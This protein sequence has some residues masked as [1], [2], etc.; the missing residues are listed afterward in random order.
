MLRRWDEIIDICIRL[1]EKGIFKIQ[2]VGPISSH[3]FDKDGVLL[4]HI[5]YYTGEL[6]TLYRLSDEDTCYVP[7]I[8]VKAFERKPLEWISSTTEITNKL[9]QVALRYH[10]DSF[11]LREDIRTVLKDHI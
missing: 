10:E 4:Y 9:V 1:Q 8:L 6:K 11:Q 5:P 3:T 7:E 2:R